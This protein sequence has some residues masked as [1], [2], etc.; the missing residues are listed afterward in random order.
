MGKLLKSPGCKK[1]PL[2][3]KTVADIV[4]ASKNMATV[5][6]IFL[7]SNVTGEGLGFLHTFLNILPSRRPW[8]TA[9]LEPAEFMIDD[10]FFITGV[11]TVVSGTLLKGQVAV[12][13]TLLLGPDSTGAF[14][15]TQIKSIH[16]KRVPVR[17]VN[18]GT[19]QSV[20]L[21]VFCVCV[22]M[23]TNAKG[24]AARSR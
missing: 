12:N 9:A 5:T 17:K 20:C 6:P 15:S 21:F 4:M 2:V 19:S 22:C 3:V 7:L 13:D 23:T 11:G 14:I 1:M 18:A 8:H 10:D 24:R 16:S